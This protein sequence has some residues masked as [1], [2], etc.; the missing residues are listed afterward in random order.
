MSRSN[1]RSEVRRRTTQPH[2]RRGFGNQEPRRPSPRPALWLAFPAHPR[3][4]YSDF[5]RS[6][7]S[8]QN[9]QT[10]SPLPQRVRPPSLGPSTPASSRL[11]GRG[12]S[13]REPDLSRR[14]LPSRR[15]PAQGPSAGQCFVRRAAQGLDR[16]LRWTPRRILDRAPPSR[17]PVQIQRQA[18]RPAPRV[19]VQP[20]GW[21]RLRSALAAAVQQ[22]RR[23]R[24]RERSAA[25]YRP[26]G[27]RA[28]RH[29]AYPR[30]NRSDWWLGRE[31]AP[32]LLNPTRRRW[33]PGRGSC[34][35]ATER[36][37]VGRLPRLGR[38]EI[39]L[40]PAWVRY[41]ETA[42]PETDPP[43]A[44]HRPVLIP[45]RHRA[46]SSRL[47]VTLPRCRPSPRCPSAATPTAPIYPARV[48]L[49]L[50]DPQSHVDGATP[51]RP[52]ACSGI[53]PCALLG[54]AVPHRVAG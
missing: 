1:R 4:H 20:P 14:Q 28:R 25:G 43:S 40:G 21:W 33:A 18:A 50:L 23:R 11:H 38:R 6:L 34:P 24:L 30:A 2:V 17:R 13:W 52:A 37:P 35:C 7:S 16:S 48:R 49:L 47:Q 36:R 46:R 19:A 22:R 9:H 44:F 32:V 29:L 15:V 31:A 27:L 26:P 12:Q 54:P 8:H 10:P 42:T 41:R 39:R 3:S 51:V 5:P 53:R 45:G